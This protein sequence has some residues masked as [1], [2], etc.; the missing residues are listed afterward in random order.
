MA[1]ESNATVV[2]GI[3]PTGELHLGNYLGA[4]RHW[5]KLQ[6]EFPC[7][8]FIADY[9]SLTEPFDPAKKEGQTMALAAELIA[10]G[11][12]PKRCTLFVQS[13]IP[14]VTELCWILNT[15]TP[16]AFLERM[17]QFKDKAARQKTNVNA[18]LF[19]Y[20]V[21]QAADVLLYH[22]SLVP[23]GGDQIQH[24]E[25][26]RDLARF[27]NKRFGEL[28]PEPKPLLTEAP[29]LMSL[30][31]PEK[32]MSKSDPGGMLA[33]TDEPQIILQ[34][35]KRAVT[36]TAPEKKERSPGVSNL[37]L[38]LEHFGT[39]DD[40]LRF[41]RV[42][43]EGTIR[44]SDL[45]TLLAERIADHFSEFRVRRAELLRDPQKLRTIL[46]GGAEKARAVAKAAMAQVRKRIGL[47]AA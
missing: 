21:L 36:D 45:K 13:H 4:I 31:D 12:D 26:T 44:Y 7:F 16:F 34:K 30:T 38:L 43:R 10:L 14:E 42:H 46:T 22:G 24:V 25:L 18:G 19:D 28:F 1:K 35:L 8:F 9:H 37:F 23:V 5:V 39:P 2:S 40:K 29:K 3:Q 33:L 17:T 6:N 27:F 47:L 20:P 15:V 41:G 11:L 32:K